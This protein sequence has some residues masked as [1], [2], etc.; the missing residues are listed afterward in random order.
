[1]TG[2]RLGVSDSGAALSATASGCAASLGASAGSAGRVAAA[3]FGLL[4]L[5]ECEVTIFAECVRCWVFFFVVFSLE[6]ANEL[7]GRSNNP[8]TNAAIVFFMVAPW[9]RGPIDARGVDTD[10]TARFNL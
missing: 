6:K 3:T 9:A 2:R 4:V 1:M 8:T 10:P 5:L 7:P